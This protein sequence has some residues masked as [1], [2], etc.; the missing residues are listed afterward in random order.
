MKKIVSS[1]L[2]I[3]LLLPSF[4]F[5]ELTPAEAGFADILGTAGASATGGVGPG[6]PVSDV[7][8]HLQLTTTNVGVGATAA[9][10]GILATKEKVLDS[11]AWTIAKRA[12]KE[13]T[14]SIVDWIDSGFDGNPAFVTDPQSFFIDLADQISGEYI[15]SLGKEN[16]L[17]SPFSLEIRSALMAKRNRRNQR[18]QCTLSTVVANMQGFLND[19]NQGGWPAWLS[20]IQEENNPYMRYL[21]E[22]ENLVRLIE[23]DRNNK[24]LELNWGSGFLS[25]KDKRTGETVTPGR[26]IAAQLDNVL[27]SNQRILELA[28][29]FDEIVSALFNQLLSQTITGASGLLGLNKKQGGGR[30]S[31]LDQL[32]NEIDPSQIIAKDGLRSIM[33]EDIELEKALVDAKENSARALINA[34]QELKGLISCLEKKTSQISVAEDIRQ[35]S[36]TIDTQ[37]TPRLNG[38]EKD[39]LTASGFIR[40]LE[41]LEQK[42][43]QTDNINV[44]SQS[45]SQYQVL[46]AGIHTLIDL[47]FARDQAN[48]VGSEMSSLVNDTRLKLTK[49]QSSI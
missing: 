49:C 40:E 35:A 32:Q 7:V 2:I 1:F 12:I 15:K 30:G 25:K 21:A 46:K 10:T 3:A 4:F 9:S 33:R 16:V 19:F 5:L 45:A 18:L 22:E 27:G 11:I 8:T 6:I 38:V 44:I 31:Y 29:E 28:D 17:C 37:I 43:A 20:L 42:V 34:R 24:T 48:A 39:I 26:T 47:G 41:N 14:A 23:N 13:I 36:T